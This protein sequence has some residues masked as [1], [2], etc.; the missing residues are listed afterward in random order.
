MLVKPGAP[1]PKTI[2]VT[3]WRRA[4]PQFN[5]HHLGDV[6]VSADLALL[7]QPTVCWVCHKCNAINVNVAVG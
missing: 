5:I 2:D 6:Q 4:I 3:V 7:L 1:A